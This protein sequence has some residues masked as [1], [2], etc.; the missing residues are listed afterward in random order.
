MFDIVHT[1]LLYLN[2]SSVLQCEVNALKY[3][4]SKMG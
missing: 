2:M 4:A 1:S 3:E